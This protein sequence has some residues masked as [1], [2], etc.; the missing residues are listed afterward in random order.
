[1]KKIKK[2]LS[3]LGPGFI[4]G[5]ADDDPS[6]I[7]TYSQTGAK[8]GYAQLWTSL[9]TFPF[10]TA[11]QEM[12]GRIGMVTGKG[13]S[14]VI[15]HH[16]P[17]PILYFAVLLLFVSN[18]INIGADLGAMA[19][20]AGLIYDIPFVV[21]L[22]GIT[23]LTLTLEV[24]VSYKVYA[25]YL[26]FLTFSLLAYVIVFFAVR[27]DWGKIIL[28][29]LIPSISLNRDYLMNIVAIFGTTISPYLFFWQSGEEAEEDVKEGKIFAMGRGTPKITRRDIKEMREDT[30]A[31]M[32]FSNIVMFF[33]I[34]T[35]AST[36]HAQGITNIETAAQAAEAL[37]PIAGDFSFLLF[38]VGIIGVGLLAVPILAGSAS[39]AVSEAFGWKEGLNRKF[40]QAHGFYAMIVV[41]TLIGVLI[42]FA[43]IPSFQM[44]YYAAILN[45]IAAPPLLVIILLISNNKKIMGE[46]TNSKFSNILGIAITI[47]MSTAALALL[48][49]LLS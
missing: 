49:D 10:M 46:R 7:A 44:L 1:M 30:Y 3:I 29:T 18:T 21:W 32:F 38:A 17:R 16:F 37:K 12:C 9:F 2:F 40:S 39:Y 43:G 42:N 26:K 11:V 48:F 34:A 6:G 35:V 8:F 45:G 23:I 41:A 47:V 28:S 5:A 31:G 36:L 19:E 33:I 20:A 4:T 25:K 22:C 13:L 14:G 15:R 24:F 27:Q